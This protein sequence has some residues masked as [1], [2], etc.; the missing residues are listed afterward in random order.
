MSLE[1]IWAEAV[2]DGQTPLSSAEVVSKVI[3]PDSSNSTFFKNASYPLAP[4]S[5]RQLRNKHY[6]KNL[7]RRNKKHFLSLKNLLRSGRGVKQQRPYCWRPNNCMTKWRSD[8]KR[9]ISSFRESCKQTLLVSLLSPDPVLSFR[10]L[11]VLNYFGG[12]MNYLLCY[13]ELFICCL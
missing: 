4:W 11:W 1:T 13:G 3:S 10:C 8:K 9:T 2:A 7:L 5:L 12:A 6:L